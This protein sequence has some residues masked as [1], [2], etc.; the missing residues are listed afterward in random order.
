MLF[1]NFTYIRCQF[2]CAGSAMA[3]P[4]QQ[5]RQSPDDPAASIRMDSAF[6]N[7]YS[8]AE[9]QMIQAIMRQAAGPDQGAVPGRE[10]IPAI[11]K[12]LLSHLSI[13][14]PETHRKPG[15]DTRDEDTFMGSMRQPGQCNEG[16]WPKTEM[17]GKACCFSGHFLFYVWI[18][19]STLLKKSIVRCSFGWL[20]TSSGVPSSTI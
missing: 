2:L 16:D 3:A 5:M 13:P 14:S 10:R 18:G 19:Y 9:P 15:N 17:S 11:F 4:A 20:I 8:G 12:A 1:G 6:V 7:L